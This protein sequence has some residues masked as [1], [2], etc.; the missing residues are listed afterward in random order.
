LTS[1]LLLKQ[2][3]FNDLSTKSFSFII[4]H[5]PHLF[6]TVPVQAFCRGVPYYLPYVYKAIS[7]IFR[8]QI[9]FT[10]LLEASDPVPV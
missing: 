10:R 7:H 1:S 9:F 5:L 8:I 2:K 3:H 6:I 4:Q